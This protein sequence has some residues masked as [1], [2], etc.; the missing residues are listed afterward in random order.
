MGVTTSHAIHRST[1]N[2]PEDRVEGNLKYDNPMYEGAESAVGEYEVAKENLGYLS[3][4]E[5]A[6]FDDE[7]YSKCT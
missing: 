5:S 7:I 6:K 1:N 4:F 3:L 2:N